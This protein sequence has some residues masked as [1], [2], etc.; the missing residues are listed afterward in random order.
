MY[1]IEQLKMLQTT[2]DEIKTV[3]GDTA[4]LQAKIDQATADLIEANRQLTTA[5]T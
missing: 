3:I 2:L 5:K 1:V 4:A